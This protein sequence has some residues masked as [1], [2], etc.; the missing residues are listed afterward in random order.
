MNQCFAGIG[1]LDSGGKNACAQDARCGM[2]N[3]F[4]TPN[5]AASLQGPSDEY[6]NDDHQVR[7]LRAGDARPCSRYI[8]SDSRL[9]RLHQVLHALGTFFFQAEDGIRD[10]SVTGVQT[11]ALPI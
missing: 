7:G 2:I 9:I 10:T 8:R 4:E 5:T 3:S 6:A 11:C 1:A